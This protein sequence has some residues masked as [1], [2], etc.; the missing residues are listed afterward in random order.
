MKITCVL[1]VSGCNFRLLCIPSIISKIILTEVIRHM[2]CSPEEVPWYGM[3]TKGVHGSHASTCGTF[4]PGTGLFFG[5]YVN[6]AF[7]SL[8]LLLF[9]GVAEILGQ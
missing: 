5:D 1:K 9:I 6:R 7:D 4:A 3:L 8:L 2:E